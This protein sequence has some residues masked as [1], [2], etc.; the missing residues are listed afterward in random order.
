MA[1]SILPNELKQFEYYV[2]KCPLYLQN[3]ENFI[4]H[5][6]IWFDFL[7]GNASNNGIV[8]TADALLDYMDIFADDYPVNDATDLLDK[9][10]SIFGLRRN[11]KFKGTTFNLTNEDFLLLIKATVIKNYSNGSYIQMKE[12]YKKAGLNIIFKSTSNAAVTVYLISLSDNEYSDD[13][14]N[15]FLKG[16]LTIKSMGIAYDF[17]ERSLD[18]PFL[19]WNNSNSL[20][21]DETTGGTWAA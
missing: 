9:L 8:G 14:K 5:F 13:V 1:D 16:L 3:C 10:G 2:K 6:R 20:W 4:E 18:K 21:G 15:M 12:F 19:V 17:I 11:F 7:M